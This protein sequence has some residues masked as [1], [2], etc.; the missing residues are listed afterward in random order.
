M[1]QIRTLSTGPACVWQLYQ[2]TSMVLAHVDGAL[3]MEYD[4]IAGVQFV[5]TLHA[6]NG[7]AAPAATR[8]DWGA[9]GT[10][11]AGSATICQIL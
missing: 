3:V 11:N 6:V 7:S 5:D 8:W 4:K 2:A 9:M 1:K 10:S